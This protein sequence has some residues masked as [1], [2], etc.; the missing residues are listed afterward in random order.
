MLSKL[1]PYKRSISGERS[2][3]WKTIIVRITLLILALVFIESIK[4]G[5]VQKIKLPDGTTLHFPRR[6]SNEISMVGETIG[7]LA[8]HNGCLRIADEHDELGFLVIWP[9][10]ATVRFYDD[11]IIEVLNSEEQVMGRVGESMWLGGGGTGDRPRDRKYVK[12]FE[13]GYRGL[14][15]DGC[16]GPYFIAGEVSPLPIEDSE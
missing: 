16:P 15:I 5:A 14:P 9:R 12:R 7:V 13:L 3:D 11:G 6:Y 4:A 8:L 2:I 1:I 10:G